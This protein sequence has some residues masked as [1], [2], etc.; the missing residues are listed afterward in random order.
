MQLSTRTYVQRVNNRRFYIQYL[1]MYRAAGAACAPAAATA[2][3]PV[4]HLT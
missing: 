1:P 3:L 2:N 4:L